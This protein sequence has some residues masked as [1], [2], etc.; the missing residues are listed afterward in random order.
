[1][2]I[3]KFNL[4]EWTRKRN[5]DKFIGAYNNRSIGQKGAC[6]LTGLC[7][8]GSKKPSKEYNLRQGESSKEGFRTGQKREGFRSC[9]I[10]PL[11]ID[12]MGGPTEED[13]QR[14][15]EAID[16]TTKTSYDNLTE[17]SPNIP[18]DDFDR[19]IKVTEAAASRHRD[20]NSQSIERPIY[21]E[22][23][24]NKRS[25]GFMEFFAFMLLGALFLVAIDRIIYFAMAFGTR[26]TVDILKQFME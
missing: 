7:G 17:A 26:Q 21:I 22:N 3:P 20:N 5:S 19:Y 4:N 25:F 14:Y 24:S 18:E 6:E 12:R 9:D 1:M 16:A 10:D 11:P 2:G 23:V 15:F 8:S 13:Q